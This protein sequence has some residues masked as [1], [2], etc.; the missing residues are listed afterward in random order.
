MP[1]AWRAFHRAEVFRSALS[2]SEDLAGLL[3][4]A[5]DALIASEE[6]RRFAIGPSAA[7][8]TGGIRST[9]R[10]PTPRPKPSAP[11]AL[12]PEQ[13]PKRARPSS[14]EP[15][16]RSEQDPGRPCPTSANPP[17]CSELDPGRLRP[18]SA[19]PPPC[20]EQDPGRPV[21]ATGRSRPSA[22]TPAHVLRAVWERD[23]GRCTHVDPAT[24]RRCDERRFIE[25]DH[26]E[27]RAFG[28]PATVDNL[29]LTCRAHNQ[30]A[31]RRV[32]GEQYVEAAIRR[33]RARGAKDFG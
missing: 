3:E 27:P 14:A 5:L 26:V 21:P 29:R 22:Y 12:R 19:N 32:L 10:T 15:A 17:P 16:P 33:A 18:T 7:R 2:F 24:G 30:H 25:L 1:R 11:S 20:S 31:A 28:G 6:K 23:Q 4:R 13:D 9:R 8:E